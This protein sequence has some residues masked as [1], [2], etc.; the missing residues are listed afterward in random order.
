D[1]PVEFG[2]A[3]PKPEGA[4][5]AAPLV[6]I[7]DVTF[8]ADGSGALKPGYTHAFVVSADGGAPRQ[9]TFGEFNERG[10]IVWSHDS[11]SLYLTGNRLEGWQRE[12]VNTEVSE[13]SVTDGAIKP[14]TTRRGPD[15]I[16]AISPDGKSLAYLSFEDRM[17]GYQNSELYLMNR[18]GSNA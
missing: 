9:L 5:W 11:R 4:D 15:S 16:Q 13:V 2:S 10:P 1:E 12:P 3:P 14:L 7:T 8:R 18:D 6:V 17:L